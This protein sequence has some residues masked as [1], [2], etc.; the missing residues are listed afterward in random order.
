MLQLSCS[1]C[2]Q[3]LQQPGAVLFSAPYIIHDLKSSVR[4]DLCENCYK[5][6]NTFIL[7]PMEPKPE[8][9]I[10]QVVPI[11]SLARAHHFVNLTDLENTVLINNVQVTTR[12]LKFNNT[13]DILGLTQND[14]FTEKKILNSTDTISKAILTKLYYKDITGA[15]Q[16]VNLSSDHEFVKNNDLYKTINLDLTINLLL[17]I[18][19][20][21]NFK[22]TTAIIS[23]QLNTETGELIVSSGN[24]H[25]SDIEL[26]GYDLYLERTVRQ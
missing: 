26:L 10:V 24:V 25:S 20:L 17:N 3:E 13:S 11:W 14:Y 15:I 4:F 2:K 8:P 5:L 23:G 6:V 12:P 16:T 1:K 7:T 21:S 22:Y 19:D 9:K 18:S